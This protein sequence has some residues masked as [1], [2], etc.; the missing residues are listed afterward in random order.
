[1]IIKPLARTPIYKIIVLILDNDRAIVDGDFVPWE[2]IPK[3]AKCF[4]N[5][6]KD[7][8]QRLIN[9]ELVAHTFG[10]NGSGRLT[11]YTWQHPDGY[12]VRI[13]FLRHLLGKTLS[14]EEQYKSLRVFADTMF[15]H[16]SS[17]GTL[18]TMSL[19]LFRST[20]SKPFKENSHATPGE[21]LQRGGRSFLVHPGEYSRASFWDIRQAYPSTLA[22][23]YVPIRWTEYIAEN[24]KLPKDIPSGFARAMVHIPWLPFGPLPVDWSRRPDYPI[25]Q[26]LV[27]VWTL[28]ELIAAEEAGCEIQY[29]RYWI[30][31]NYRQPFTK[32]FE[33]MRGIS[34][35]LKGTNS[36]KLAKV[37][38]NSFVG[39][40]AANGRQSSYWYKEGRLT[41]GQVYGGI[42]PMSLSL[43]GLVT[44]KVRA[45]LYS[46]A[47][48]P[49]AGAIISVHTDGAVL[50]DQSDVTVEPAGELPG[51]WRKKKVAVELTIHTPQ[52][53]TYSDDAFHVNYVVA[54]VSDPR[55]AKRIFDASNSWDG[56]GREK[57][58][59][60]PGSVTI[61]ERAMP[62]KEAVSFG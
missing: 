51:E 48:V 42:N 19:S 37:C 22:S 6:H 21:Y 24:G 30:G 59:R 55:I 52:V 34:E 20:L 56:W 26:T 23:Q 16:G 7:I 36:A 35:S 41:Y 38:A 40:F 43:H 5:S 29:S 46:E 54:G 13:S 15:E 61:R 25:E 11:A 12:P 1:M 39:F 50:P 32:W 57:D 28:D 3:A 60:V 33:I 10:E 44:S 18:G 4:V 31:T 53:Y 9:G 62:T 49:N 2:K 58:I 14:P 47:I 8:D 45:R 27:G 17:I